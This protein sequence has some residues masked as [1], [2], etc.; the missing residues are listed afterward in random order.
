M[1][2]TK[3]LDKIKD[4]KIREKIKEDWSGAV[5]PGWNDTVEVDV[6]GDPHVYF[7]TIKYTDDDLFLHRV[8]DGNL[9]PGIFLNRENIDFLGRVLN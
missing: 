7:I 9:S 1:I 6:H 3:G 8:V 2:K 5:P 4:E